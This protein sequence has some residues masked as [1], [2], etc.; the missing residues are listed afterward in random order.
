MFQHKLF[1]IGLH[2]TATLSLHKFVIQNGYISLHEP[3][4]WSWQ[5]KE[6]FTEDVGFGVRQIYSD[7]FEGNEFRSQKPNARLV[8]PDLEFLEE[9]FPD[10]KFVLNTRPLNKWMC[11]RLNHK[12]TVLYSAYGED[13]FNE[14]TFL[15]W[16]VYRNFWH[17]TV[18]DYFKNK[19]KL[20][21]ADFTSGIES[22]NELEHFLQTKFVNKTFPHGHKTGAN[23][24]T[25]N[26]I[27]KFLD[28]Y[29]HKE[30]HSTK[31]IT[32]LI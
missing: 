22:V 2:K 8:F 1:F 32:K 25:K 21:I 31:L 13:S 18:T 17:K 29:V 9:S 23:V 24:K 26:I 3:Q 10:A 16:I 4:W 15:N 12:S 14:H 11:S 27:S 28:K 7:G 19:S 6:R 5:E 30:Y 20:L